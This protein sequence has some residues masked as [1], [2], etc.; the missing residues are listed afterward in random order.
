LSSA[1]AVSSASNSRVAGLEGV[2][3]VLQAER[4][5]DEQ[6]PSC[7]VLVVAQQGSMLPR[8]LSAA[9]LKFRQTSGL[10]AE[11]VED[12]RQPIAVPPTT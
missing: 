5:E 7:D 4:E 6:K 3:D 2:G 10:E 9:A 11:H 12:N 8:S 1:A